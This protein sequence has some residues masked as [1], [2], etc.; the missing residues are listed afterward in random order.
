MTV[1]IASSGCGAANNPTKD[2][3]NAKPAA[4]VNQKVERQPAAD[5]IAS[6]YH[7]TRGSQTEFATLLAQFRKNRDSFR[8]LRIVE[9]RNRAETKDYYLRQAINCEMAAKGSNLSEQ[10]KR[11]QLL[12]SKGFRERAESAPATSRSF[13]DFY[14][15]RVRFQ[16]R[17]PRKTADAVAWQFPD[18]SPAPDLL[19][20]TYKDYTIYSFTASSER[21]LKIWTGFAGKGRTWGQIS[22]RRDY[23]G[24]LDFWFPPLTIKAATWGAQNWHPIDA[25][26]RDATDRVHVI[27]D[28]RLGETTLTVVEW[29][30]FTDTPVRSEQGDVLQQVA[31]AKAWID[32]NRGA[33]PLRIEERAGLAIS[34]RVL[35]DKLLTRTTIVT[36]IQAIEGAGH[37][38]IKGTIETY[39]NDPAWNEPFLVPADYFAGKTQNVPQ[40]VGE[41]VGWNVEQVEANSPMDA[42]MFALNFPADVGL[43]DNGKPVGKPTDV[44]PAL[45]RG[46]KV[47]E[48]VVKG[49]T[50]ERDRTVADYRGKVLVLDF[51]GTWCGPCRRAIPM[52]N[53]L[54]EKYKQ[55][56]VVF[57][58]IHTAG[59]D[60][61]EV[62]AGL[63]ELDYQV[64]C[65]VD[66]GLQI[67]D[68]ATASRYGIRGYPTIM[69]VRPDGAVA[70]NSGDSSDPAAF[71][72][73]R[74][75]V[76]K[77][78]NLPQVTEEMSKEAFAAREMK[79][80]EKFLTDGIEGALAK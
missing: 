25:F 30:R 71:A 23:E 19:P 79:V 16:A 20:T 51:W 12:N 37:Y 57:L 59:P 76:E 47:P 2:L 17:S 5:S 26:F 64:V 67:Q 63:K 74:T 52:M 29:M 65:A 54:K 33:I 49:W 41:I 55:D 27:G 24:R 61:D 48:W 35:H 11:D 44:A 42:E 8:T 58:A 70:W 1:F 21:P 62:R 18:D 72:M 7:E 14:T 50:D 39:V 73:R 31:M 22:S 38:P 80:Y 34:G 15:D 77:A 40:V 66:S 78:L 53:R 60:L 9:Q 32:R 56:D 45:A 36:E 13:Q 46:A 43:L 4:P 3:S 69:I 68:G 75:E 10:A 28:E 6:G